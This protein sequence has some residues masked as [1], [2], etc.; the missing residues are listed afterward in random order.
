MAF[1]PITEPNDVPPP[2]DVEPIN[3]PDR[4]PFQHD[5]PPRDEPMDPGTVPVPKPEDLPPPV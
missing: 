4:D 2:P 3:D 5:Q 1:P